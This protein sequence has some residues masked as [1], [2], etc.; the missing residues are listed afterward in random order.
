MTEIFK[1]LCIK[2]IPTNYEISNLGSVRNILT[3]KLLAPNI[4][5]SGYKLVK[6]TTTTYKERKHYRIHRLVAT[7]FLSMDI[8]SPLFVNH[9][10]GNKSNNRLDNL[11]VVTPSENTRH[12]IYTGL[13]KPINHIMYEKRIRG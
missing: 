10:D 1:P 6:I 12:A 3:G 2:G 13:M 11:E 4:H 7:T 8:D 5:P 9:I